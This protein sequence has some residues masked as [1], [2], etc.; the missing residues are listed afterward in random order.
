MADTAIVIDADACVPEPLARELHLILAPADAPLFDASDTIP[1]LGLASAPGAVEPVAQACADAAEGA[2]AVLYVHAHDEH[3]VATGVVPFARAAVLAR[4]PDVRFI[5]HAAN[6]ALMGA[7][8]QAVAAAR[9][10]A[11]GA[12]TE[13][14]RTVAARV[15]TRASVLALLEHPELSGI[16][17]AKVPGTARLRALVAIRGAR[18]DVLMRPKLREDGLVALRDRFAELA[19]GGTGALHIAVHHAGAAAGAEA[20]ATWI[21]RQLAPDEL[22]IA[23][24][25]RHAASRYGPRM[26]GVAWYRE[27]D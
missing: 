2:G 17:G 20:L 16:G 27:A 26:I 19:G 7:G 21:R 14:A 15:G 18:M 4:A 25:T 10:I 9:A 12:D 13:G 3:S 6:A 24:I 8:W 23:P 22:L 11:G 1:A 5:E